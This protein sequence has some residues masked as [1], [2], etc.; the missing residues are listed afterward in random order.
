MTNYNER[1]DEILGHCDFEP[2]VDNWAR[3]KWCGEGQYN[4]IH[5]AKQAL[6]SLIK[7]LVEEAK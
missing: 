6:T 2:E 7:E 1:L 3:C 4:R 5:T